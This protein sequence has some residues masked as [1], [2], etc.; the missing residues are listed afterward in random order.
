MIL[1]SICKCQ[2]ACKISLCIFD[3]IYL[4][5]I[6]VLILFSTCKCQNAC[7]ISLSEI[8]TITN[9]NM[10]CGTFKLSSYIDKTDILKLKDGIEILISSNNEI[11]KVKLSNEKCEENMILVK[12]EI[13][14]HSQIN[15]CAD[16]SHFVNATF[17]GFNSNTVPV[18]HLSL[19]G[20]YAI[21]ECVLTK[22]EDFQFNTKVIKHFKH[23][24]CQSY[25]LCHGYNCYRKLIKDTSL[26]KKV[27]ASIT[28]GDGSVFMVETKRGRKPTLHPNSIQFIAKDFLFI[29]PWNAVCFRLE[30]IKKSRDI[31]YTDFKDIT[32]GYIGIIGKNRRTFVGTIKPW[33]GKCKS[34]KNP[35]NISSHYHVCAQFNEQLQLPLHKVII[36]G[37][38]IARLTTHAQLTKEIT[39]IHFMAPI[40]QSVTSSVLFR[41]SVFEGNPN[42]FLTCNAAI[43]EEGFVQCNNTWHYFSRDEMLSTFNKVSTNESLVIYNTNK[44]NITLTQKISQQSNS[45]SN[46]NKLSINF[47][48]FS[49]ISILHIFGLKI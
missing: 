23:L 16:Y 36:K 12:D 40:E 7:R 21:Q 13:R 28:K 29:H 6:L 34:L 5:S 44:P 11:H 32:N 43:D 30:I 46:G 35:A 24:D 15:I 39:W 42:C 33:H 8:T 4:F 27:C 17:F 26:C 22:S 14:E 10:I 3:K 31:I 9:A 41:E 38:I 37:K 1:F 18:Q 2:N 20:E 45:N 49:I 25:L 48:L 47:C 19:S